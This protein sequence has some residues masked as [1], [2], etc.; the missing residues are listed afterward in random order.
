MKKIMFIPLDERPCNYI[1][2]QEIVGI[3]GDVELI[4]PPIDM[5]GK[6]KT[7]ADIHRLWEFVEN[8]ISNCQ[9]FVFSVEMLFYGGLLPSRLHHYSNEYFDELIQRLELLKSNHK[10]CA[11]YTFQLI[12]R[13]PR[14]SSDDEEPDYYGIFGE[15]IFKR[16]YLINKHNRVGITNQEDKE[17]E[18]YN[19]L[20]PQE[21]IDD[22]EIRRCVNL[23][24]NLKMIELVK[25]GVIDFLSIPQDDSCEFGYTAMDQQSVV[26]AISQLRL[27]RKVMML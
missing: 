25:K 21:V 20:I 1:Y 17:L 18:E 27:Q 13:T 15:Q 10:D 5:L 3:R 12:M 14:Y 9:A 24:V 26:Q 19:L 23:R 8:H 6:K 11:F 22:Y 2:P 4:I 16:S 7:P